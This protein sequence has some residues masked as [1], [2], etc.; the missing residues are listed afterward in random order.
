MSYFYFFFL[1]P[2]RTNLSVAA[3]LLLGHIK[4]P[5]LQASVKR[6]SARMWTHKKRTGFW[7]IPP[8]VKEQVRLPQR[9]ER[10]KC[11][12]AK[13]RQGKANN[14]ACDQ[15]LFSFQTERRDR[16]GNRYSTRMVQASGAPVYSV[17]FYDNMLMVTGQQDM[18]AV[19]NYH[20]RKRMHTFSPPHIPLSM[21][22]WRDD[23]SF[24]T[25]GDTSVHIWDINGCKEKQHM[26]FD[27]P[28][29]QITRNFSKSALVSVHDN[30]HVTLTDLQTGKVEQSVPLFSHNS[31]NSNNN[32]SNNVTPLRCLALHPSSEN[33]VVCG[34][35]DGSVR[36]LDMRTFGCV[37]H[38]QL[39]SA[40]VSS[41]AVTD[42][43][44]VVTASYDGRIGVSNINNSSN[45]ETNF[46]L[47]YFG[48]NY[49]IPLTSV[50]WVTDSKVLVSSMDST[51]RLINYSNT[52]DNSNYSDHTFYGHGG[53][54]LSMDYDGMRMVS[55]D[56][57]GTV[58][59]WQFEQDQVP[60]SL[61]KLVE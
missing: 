1:S 15:T 39:H 46:T 31:N 23:R 36:V 58:L 59:V 45:N 11:R 5:T 35:E 37:Q 30:G 14:E 41:L 29:W 8:S 9:Q 33:L 38:T 18:V 3:V 53:C 16:S 55:G 26:T 21:Q 50:R 51:I 48:E 54:V 22:S 6:T 32:S 34:G 44:T 7:E 10:N 28:V 57:T 40:V 52:N 49:Q 25:C 24:V 13:I 2:E 27:S 4:L 12:R 60:I 43:G 17:G 20:T 47:S 61:K 56:L 42:I 19:W